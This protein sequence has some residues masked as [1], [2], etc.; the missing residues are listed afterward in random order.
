MSVNQQKGSKAFGVEEGYAPYRLRQ[1]RYYELGMDCARWAQETYEETG[2]KAD[3]LDVGS[4]DGALRKYTEIHAGSE[5]INY[6]GVDIFP[7]GKDFVYKSEDW[8]LHHINLEEGLTELESDRY[9]VVVCE[10]VLE[11]LHH[12]DVAIADMY[13]VLKPG[14]RLVIGVPIFPPGLDAVRRH[15]VP[16]TDRLFGVKKI[17]GH[18]QAWSKFSF[19]RLIRNTVP[20]AEI[21]LSR[22]FRIVSGGILR[23]LEYCRWWWQLA[24][25]V[26][27]T[28]PS[29][30]IEIQTV[31]SKPER[32]I[33]KMPTLESQSQV[34][35]R[36]A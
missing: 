5:Q 7:N 13:R 6:H 25:A 18:V 34:A 14:G 36:A 33:L 3:V 10:Q 9:D 17:R 2:R 16:K 23:P 28:V 11:H 29:L 26:G 27:R 22:G 31:V 24:R 35:A 30:C 15:V 4:W 19:E 21:E 1:A 12:P 20:E 32:M 8:T